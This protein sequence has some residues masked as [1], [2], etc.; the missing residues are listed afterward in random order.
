MW[1]THDNRLRN[2]DVGFMLGQSTQ[3]RLPE[4]NYAVH[5]VDRARES[6]GKLCFEVAIGCYVTISWWN[7]F[8]SLTW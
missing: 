8:P 2:I 3:K 5:R 6:S 7:P 4:Q 1:T